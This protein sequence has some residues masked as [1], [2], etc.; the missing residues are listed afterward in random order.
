M[1]ENQKLQKTLIVTQLNCRR[2]NKYKIE[3]L[4]ILEKSKTTE[5]N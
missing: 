5:R 1:I 2:L 3:I 4:N